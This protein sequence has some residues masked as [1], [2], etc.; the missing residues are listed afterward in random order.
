MAAQGYIGRSPG[1]SSVIIARQDYSPSGVTTDFTFTSGYTVGYVDTYFNGVRLIEATDFT[2]TDGSTVSLVE[3]A[4]DGDVIEII[5]YK[6]F[7]VG[8]V[9]NATGDF[10]VGNDLTVSNN[11][12]IS[13]T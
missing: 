12:T 10:T 5:A 9:T 4:G 2:A 13:G 7:D 8:N 3:A 11:A 1:E 6:A